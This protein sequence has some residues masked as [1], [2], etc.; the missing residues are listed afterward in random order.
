VG[1]NRR[2]GAINTV[3]S[4]CSWTEPWARNDPPFVDNI[5]A[6]H[7]RYPYAG[8]RQILVAMAGG[9]G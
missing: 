4:A 3:F 5:A 6:A 8:N 1:S 7:C 2:P 9:E